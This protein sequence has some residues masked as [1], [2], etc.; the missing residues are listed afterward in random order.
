MT[1]HRARLARLGAACAGLALAACGG[2]EQPVRLTV[3]AGASFAQVADSL[4]ARGLVGS[5]RLF[6]W[7]AAVGGRDR[8]IKA[9]TYQ[10]SA[11]QSWGELLDA[12]VAGR[13]LVVTVTIPEGFD[14]RRIVPRLARALEVPEDSVRAAVADSTSRA[15]RGISAPT[16]EGYLFPDTYT[17]PAGTSAREAVRTMLARFDAM[18]RPEWDARLTALGITKHEAVTMAALVEK[19]ARVASERPTIAAVYWNRVRIGMRLQADPTVQYALPEHVDR[20]LFVHLEVDSPYNTYRYDGLPPGPIASPGAASL[21]AALQPADVP[22]LFFVAHPDGHHEFT[23]TFQEHTRAIAIVRREARRRQAAARASA[24][25]T[26]TTSPGQ[27]D[28]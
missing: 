23:R 12:L 8:A 24:A 19:E 22:Y 5:T 11:S 17:F 16:L 1:V 3:P 18:W 7:Y 21:E 9:G 4:S 28:A 13:G 6:R 20:L 27:P 2:S 10:L 14:L 26:T 25:P 15:S